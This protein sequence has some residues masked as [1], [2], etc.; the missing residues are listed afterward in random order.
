MLYNIS[1]QHPALLVLLIFLLLLLVVE[2][3]WFVSAL[4]SIIGGA[5]FVPLNRARAR[6]VWEAAELKAGEKVYELGCGDARHLIDACRRYGVIGVGIDISWW[7]LLLAWLK[8]RLRGMGGQ[9]KLICGNIHQVDLSGADVVYLYL[10]QRLSDALRPKL[11]RELKSGARV[12]SAQ[13]PITG[14]TPSKV[15]GDAKR[16]IYVYHRPPSLF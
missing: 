13:F 12:I 5:P 3:V 8:S 2:V 6:Q 1:V 16:S 9:I 4:Q 11:E 14:W 15:V 7:P 10:G